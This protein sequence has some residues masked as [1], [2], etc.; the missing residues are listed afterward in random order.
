MPIAGEQLSK[1]NHIIVM[2]SNMSRSIEFYENIIGF[3]LKLCSENWAEFDVGNIVFALH[4]GG[5]SKAKNELEPHENLSGTSSISF[6][7]EDVEKIYR[8]LSANGVK[9]TFPPT[10]RQ[11]EGIKLAIAQDLDGF[12][13]C[14]A[15]KV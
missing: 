8:D 14:F 15:E 11:G 9:F 4:G 5:K 3:K 1:I 6:D 7:V 13:L 2:V 12:E 10:L